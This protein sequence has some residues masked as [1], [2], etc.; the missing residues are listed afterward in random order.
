MLTNKMAIRKMRF[1][2]DPMWALPDNVLKK[3]AG[4]GPLNIH[5]GMDF[6]GS[7][8]PAFLTTETAQMVNDF[9]LLS[10]HREV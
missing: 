4:R 1:F 3:P 9:N 2:H 5:V 10:M 8:N 7:D 6:F